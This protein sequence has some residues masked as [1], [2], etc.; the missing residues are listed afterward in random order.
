MKKS[1]RAVKTKS[2]RR[3]IIDRSYDYPLLIITIILIAFGFIAV[4]SS[5]YPEGLKKMD[6]GYYFAKKNIFYTLIGTVA[7]IIMANMPRKMLKMFTPIIYVCSVCFLLLLWSPLGVE[8][9]GQTRWV[10]L[11]IIKF[12]FQPSDF[13]KIAL[14]LMI[15]AV[16]ESNIKRLNNRNVFLWLIGIS[17]VGGG[18]VAV[19]DLSTAIVLGAEV[20]SIFIVGGLYAYQ[21][22]ILGGLGAVALGFLAFG[23]D[24]RRKRIF[25]LFKDIGTAAT[26][27]DTYQI[28]QAL[29]AVAMGGV[30][31]VGLFHSKQKY[32]NVPLAYNDFIYAIICEEFGII[33]GTILIM[34]FIAFI[35]RGYVIAYRANNIFDK[36]TA[37]GITT[38]IGVQ[39]AFNIGV[40]IQFFPVTG[41]TLPFISYGGTAL[42]VA[43]GA[44]GILL[45]ISRDI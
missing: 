28:D 25:A 34:L 14:V 16:M 6:D 37:V 38:Y 17:V 4:M 12:E 32:Y 39:A 33:G 36:L 2:R 18:L 22:V 24:Y 7:M 10:R 8:H 45:R 19:K 21:F 9:Y 20:L 1:G 13:M 41:I 5:S 35:Y 43:M 26:K 44:V 27:Q 30:G 29:Y 3:K 15:A 42:I 31:G 23:V 40:S 11:P